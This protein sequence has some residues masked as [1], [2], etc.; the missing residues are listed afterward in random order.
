MKAISLWQPWASLIA[1][2][3]KKI[4]TRSWPT[5]YRGPLLIHA[6]KRKNKTEFTALGQHPGFCAALNTEWPWGYDAIE[7]LPFGALIAVVDL[8]NCLPVEKISS[9]ILDADIR[10]EGSKD[11]YYERLLGNYE[12]GRY[13]WILAN[14][15][16]ITPIDYKGEQGLFNVPDEIIKVSGAKELAR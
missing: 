5:Y 15:R 11:I 14:P 7:K 8:V 3:A 2:G 10:R 6:A 9:D 13:G 16:P 12:S 1:S 4:E